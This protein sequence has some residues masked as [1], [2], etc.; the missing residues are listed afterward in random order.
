MR[1]EEAGGTTLVLTS[2][3]D[4]YQ[5]ASERTT[6]LRPKRGVSELERVGPD[7]VREIYGVEP[8]Q[9]PEF[10][11]LRGDTADKIPGARG[12]GA[13]RAAQILKKHETEIGRASCRG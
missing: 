4:L 9:V 7:E 6:I 8:I 2:D 12:I 11:A 13:G 3:R 10:V 1:E 5:L